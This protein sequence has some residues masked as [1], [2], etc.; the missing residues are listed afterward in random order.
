MEYGGS[1]AEL[2]PSPG[3]KHP[4]G[5]CLLTLSLP[6]LCLSNLLPLCGKAWHSLMK[7]GDHVEESLIVLDE[8]LLIQPTARCPPNT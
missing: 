5:F 6:C 3:L 4:W 8:S 1:D 2:V 7:N